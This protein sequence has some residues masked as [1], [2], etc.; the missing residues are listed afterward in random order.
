[1]KSF[2]IIAVTALVLP[3]LVFGQT[4]TTSLPNP[5]LTPDSPF[6][7][8]NR[9]S[10]AL[11]ELFA[12]SPEAKARLQ[13][14]F[15]AE[16]IA[17]IKAMIEA[18]GATTPGIDTAKTILNENLAKASKVVTSEKAS[19]RDVSEL[20]KEV[21]ERITEQKLTLSGVFGEKKKKL[22]EEEKAARELLKKADDDGDTEEADEVSKKLSELGVEREALRKHDSER[23]D[24]FDSEDDEVDSVLELKDQAQSAIEDAKKHRVELLAELPGLTSDDLALGDKAIASA[25]SLFAKE[26]YQ[27]AK[28]LA[29]QAEKAFERAKDAN[30]REV[31]NELKSD[32]RSEELMRK[33]EERSREDASEAAE[34]AREAAK[35]QA[36][37][38]RE[39]SGTSTD[40]DSEDED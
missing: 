23:A 31:E 6:Y 35:K 9:V 1:M 19:G 26:N 37:L 18:R 33:Y 34:D 4:A 8:L 29:H 11:Q 32:E 40:S 15:A 12:F 7:F 3:V 14:E 38:N 13:L 24:D 28:E 30:E 22:S 20:A 2:K 21:S 17:E 16:R 25:E 10:E 27:A 5:G 36:E 39:T